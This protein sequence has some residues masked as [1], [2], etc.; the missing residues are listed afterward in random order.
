MRLLQLE[1]KYFEYNG[2]YCF[3][4]SNS[5]SQQNIKGIEGLLQNCI[6]WPARNENA[7][8]S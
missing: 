4:K 5:Q 6:E 2:A 3:S 8:T 7:S 1:G